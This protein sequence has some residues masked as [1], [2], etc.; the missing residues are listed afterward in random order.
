MAGSAVK[1]EE[2]E[3]V[4]VVVDAV[5]VAQG[6]YGYQRRCRSIPWRFGRTRGAPAVVRGSRDRSSDGKRFRRSGPATCA[7][8]AE[9]FGEWCAGAGWP[10]GGGCVSGEPTTASSFSAT[11]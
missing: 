10:G 11:A 9:R 6:Y 1:A 3:P 2:P 5:A 4:Q 8:S 7:S